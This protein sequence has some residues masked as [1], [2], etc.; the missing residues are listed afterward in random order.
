M[1]PAAHAIV[2]V[3][4]AAE[5]RQDQDPDECRRDALDVHAAARAQA[6]RGDEP[7]PGRGREPL[8]G[9]AGPQDRAAGQ[10]PIPETTDAA[11]R[12]LSTSMRSPW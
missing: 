1:Q 8:H 3:L 2:L 12:E 5:H 4:E 10:K 9:D 7:Q 6:D 11:I